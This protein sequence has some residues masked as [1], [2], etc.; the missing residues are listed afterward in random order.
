M[1]KARFCGLPL[2]KNSNWAKMVHIVLSQ[3]KQNQK[4]TS[5]TTTFLKESGFVA[6]QHKPAL[7]Q[8]KKQ[9][10]L[11]GHIGEFLVHKKFLFQEL[12]GGVRNTFSA[13]F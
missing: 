8:T 6:K 5:E 4:H 2:G 10:T 11:I 7:A 12:I 13:G 1:K 9:R 3:L